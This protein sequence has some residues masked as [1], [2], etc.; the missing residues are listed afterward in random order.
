MTVS[1]AQSKEYQQAH[2]AI[3]KTVAA[4][5]RRHAKGQPLTQLAAELKISASRLQSIV[6]C[7]AHAGTSMTT[8]FDLAAL[9]GVSPAVFFPRGKR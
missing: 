3:T 6:R 2:K 9:F 7:D 5:I 1:I 8:I 4:A